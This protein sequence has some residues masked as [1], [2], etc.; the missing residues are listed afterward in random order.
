MIMKVSIDRDGCIGCGLCVN[1]CPAVFDMA[2]DG[3]AEVIA[4]PGE[5]DLKDAIAAVDEC[6]VSVISL[7]D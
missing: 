7:E 5:A 6:P 3:K 4:Q 2:E 1:I